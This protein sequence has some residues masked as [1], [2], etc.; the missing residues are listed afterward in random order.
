MLATTS[1]LRLLQLASP[2]LPVG[3]YSYSEGLETLISQGII[4]NRDTLEDWLVRSLELGTVRLEAA[5]MLRASQAII[6]GNLEQLQYWNHWA[7]A[8]RET[9]ELRQQSWQMG[10][11]L[12]Q[13]LSE[14][15]L[16]AGELAI[17][18]LLKTCHP[19][20]FSIAFGI[21]VA[22][23]QIDPPL[24][25]LGYLQS[26]TTNLI[27]AGIKLI[28]LGQT[29]GQQLLYKLDPI[30]QITSETILQLADD[31]LVSCSWGLSLASM[32]HET[33]YSRLFRS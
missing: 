20:N 8:S 28:P 17:S 3:A 30:L 7:T 12:L 16:D 2:V 15:Q 29:T 18:D 26:W 33:Q 14:L 1:L 22:G 31:D 24:A 5:L 10:R 11:T 25:V 27:N 13:L 19:I 32:A 9:E 21:G 4:H 6:A 23:W